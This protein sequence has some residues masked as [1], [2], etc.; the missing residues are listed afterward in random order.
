MMRGPGARDPG[1]GRAAPPR[2]IVTGAWPTTGDGTAGSASPVGADAVASGVSSWTGDRRCFRTTVRRCRAIASAGGS[3]GGKTT[4]GGT[5]EEATAGGS[6][7]GEATAG[8]SATG[9]TTDGGGRSTTAGDGRS[10]TAGDGGATTAG[11]CGAT[12]AGG[13]ASAAACGGSS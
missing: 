7:T 8:G 9:D 12:T 2:S 1:L 11:D 3:A 5:A 4:G 6:A 10:T 13:G